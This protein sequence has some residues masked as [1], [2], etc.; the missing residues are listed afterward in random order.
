MKINLKLISR[1]NLTHEIKYK[2][3]TNVDI[4]GIKGVNSFIFLTFWHPVLLFE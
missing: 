4:F 1:K 3:E 2:S